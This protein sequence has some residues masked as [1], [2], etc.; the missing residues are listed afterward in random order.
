MKIT[1]KFPTL[2]TNTDFLKRQTLKLSLDL[3]AHLINVQFIS[4]NVVV[5][6]Y[7]LSMLTDFLQI[8]HMHI[9]NTE[10]ILALLS[11]KKKKNL[12]LF[13]VLYLRTDRFGDQF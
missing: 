5:V 4:I 8:D 6:K 10:M 9:Q 1:C 13:P 2:R 7:L 12:R 3:F 11:K